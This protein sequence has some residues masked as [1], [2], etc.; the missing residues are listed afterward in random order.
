MTR[1]RG[2]EYWSLVTKLGRR[3]LEGDKQKQIPIAGSKKGR[4]KAPDT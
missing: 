2:E 1:T 4:R 3:K